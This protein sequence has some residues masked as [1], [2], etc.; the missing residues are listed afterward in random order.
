VSWRR[1]D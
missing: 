1:I